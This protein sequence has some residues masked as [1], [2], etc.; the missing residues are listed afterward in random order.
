MRQSHEQLMKVANSEISAQRS[1]SDSKNERSS[2]K[3]SR[4]NR[5]VGINI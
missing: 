1:E 2:E 5:G 3:N 4:L